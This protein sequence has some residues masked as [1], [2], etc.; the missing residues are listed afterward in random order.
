MTIVYIKY[1]NTT[2]DKKIYIYKCICNK[3]RKM[4]KKMKSYTPLNTDIKEGIVL[5]HTDT[6]TQRERA[7]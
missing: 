1:Y 7:R 4:T 2:K 3:S 5:T 6:H